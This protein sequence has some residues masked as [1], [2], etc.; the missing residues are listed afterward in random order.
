MLRESG[1]GSRFMEKETPSRERSGA[2]S[3]NSSS[4]GLPQDRSE[5]LSRYAPSYNED[6]AKIEKNTEISFV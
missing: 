6:A 3:G 5:H 1:D 2:V 4:E